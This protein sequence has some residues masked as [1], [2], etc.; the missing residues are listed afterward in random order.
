MANE[1]KNL[2]Q[3]PHYMDEFCRANEPHTKAQTKGLKGLKQAAS[4]IYSV[5]PRE[6]ELDE[7]EVPADQLEVAKP[8]GAEASGSDVGDIPVVEVEEVSSS[9]PEGSSKSE[10]FSDRLRGLIGKMKRK[11]KQD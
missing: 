1:D 4:L 10:K 7:V 8:D 5:T 2:T 6:K 9:G 11:F 3:L